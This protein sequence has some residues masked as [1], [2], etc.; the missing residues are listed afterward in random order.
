MASGI[1]ALGGASSASA[2]AGSYDSAEASGGRAYET[3]QQEI[4]VHV[5]GEIAG[6]KI[7]LAGQKTLNKWNR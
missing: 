2:S 5:V 4:T 6:D 3:Y 7:V 1:R